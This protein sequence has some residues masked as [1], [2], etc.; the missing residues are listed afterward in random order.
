MQHH[1]SLTEPGSPAYRRAVSQ[2][3]RHVVVAE[4]DAI[5]RRLIA[6]TLRR[7]GF[8]VSEAR[9][10]RE[11]VN[12]MASLAQRRGPAVDLIISDIRMPVMTGL[13]ALAGLRGAD[14]VTP[15][16]LITAFGD[17]E[18]RLEA[19]RLGADALFAKPF[20]LNDLRTM[21]LHLAGP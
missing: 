16:I 19:K 18:A 14:W 12:H 9:D 17:D 21:A 13:D 11:L 1:L 2:R 15:V 6:V 8:S 10:G 5:F 3:T 7:D 4:D 20:E